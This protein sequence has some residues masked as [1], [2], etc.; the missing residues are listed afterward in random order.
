MHS[1][2]FC[3]KYALNCVFISF[4]FVAA[5]QLDNNLTPK[6]IINWHK[7]INII[8]FYLNVMEVL[9]W[10]YR[11]LFA[12]H[13]VHRLFFPYY[14]LSQTL[15]DYSFLSWTVIQ[16]TGINQFRFHHHLEWKCC[17]SSSLWML[18]HS[19]V[20]SFVLVCFSF[21]FS[22]VCLNLLCSSLANWNVTKYPYIVQC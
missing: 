21:L 17:D 1:I 12:W 4:R 10:L 16:L 20:R 13:C 2:H 5:L 19:F 7:L 14:F 11:C 15:F 6:N 8:C 9:C 3:T 18:F 22:F